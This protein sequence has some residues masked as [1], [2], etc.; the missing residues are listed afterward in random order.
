MIQSS[1][2]ELSNISERQAASCNILWYE[3]YVIWLFTSVNSENL[4]FFKNLFILFK[5]ANKDMK[6]LFSCLNVQLINN[7]LTL[8]A[9]RF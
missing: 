3:Y 2:I 8:R 4:L 9:L 1:I 6:N 5:Q 7:M